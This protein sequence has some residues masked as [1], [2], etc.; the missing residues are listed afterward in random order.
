[1]GIG[2][3]LLKPASKPNALRLEAAAAP[4]MSEF[5]TTLQGL[6]VS[7]RLLDGS[8]SAEK[9]LA[10]AAIFRARQMN[11]DTLS[12]LPVTTGD[13]LVPAPNAEQDTQDFVSDIVLGMLDYGEAYIEVKANGDMRVMNPSGMAVDWEDVGAQTGRRLYTYHGRPMR[14]VGLARNLLVAAMNRGA[15]ALKGRGPMQSK[16]IAGLIAEQEYSQEY[17]ENNA[18]PTGTLEHPGVLTPKEAKAL[19]DAW[20]AGQAER[21]TGVLSGGLKYNPESFNPSVSD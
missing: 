13:G 8:F 7:S 2:D 19:Y 14:T 12:S 18:Q 11:A 17:Y 21:S 20:L 1:V 15:N 4:A 5:H 10:V 9:A 6:V 16:R 3:W